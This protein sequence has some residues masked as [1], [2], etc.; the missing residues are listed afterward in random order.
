MVRILRR[1]WPCLILTSYLAFAVT[2]AFTL[3][4]FETKTLHFLESKGKLINSSGFLTSVNYN[5]DCLAENT[6]TPGRTSRH[7][8]NVLCGWWLRT[9]VPSDM[10]TGTYSTGSSLNTADEYYIPIPKNSI[11]IK[12]RI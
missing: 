8:S 4:A 11:L 2:G 10:Q 5:I 7:S 1:K 3:S 12:F 9:F 6:V